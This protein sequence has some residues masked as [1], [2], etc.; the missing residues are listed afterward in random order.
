MDIVW[1]FL[2]CV[3]AVFLHRF[4]HRRFNIIYFGLGA[5]IK[6]WIVCFIIAAFIAY[7]AMSWLL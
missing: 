4:Y 3:I 1:F 2:V 5:V 7:F 6:E